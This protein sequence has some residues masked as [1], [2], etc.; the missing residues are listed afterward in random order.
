MKLFDCIYNLSYFCSLFVVCES[1]I[2]KSSDAD[3][4]PVRLNRVE[5]I[6][7]LCRLSPTASALAATICVSLCLY[8][9][10]ITRSPRLDNHHSC[11]V[12]EYTGEY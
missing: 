9:R 12:Y 10:Q 2:L 11:L 7:F 4:D 1:L 5:F 6:K 8:T 3:P